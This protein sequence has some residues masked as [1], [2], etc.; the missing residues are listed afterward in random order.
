VATPIAGDVQAY[1]ATS[2]TPVARLVVLTPPN[3]AQDNAVAGPEQACALAV[4][5]RDAARRAAHG[6][7]RARLFLATPLGL[8]LLL[9]HRW[10][11]VA[12]TVVYEDLVALGYD[13]AFTVSA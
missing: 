3:G 4:G 10:N 9:G 2:G 5:I 11:R 12:P 1:L 7:P 6:H 8:A 13:A